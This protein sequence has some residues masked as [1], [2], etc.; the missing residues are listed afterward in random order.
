MT[1]ALVAFAAVFVTGE[2]APL[3]MEIVAARSTYENAK[4]LYQADPAQNQARYVKATVSYGTT[5]MMSPVMDR[6]LKYKEA[7]KLYR[8]ALK[9]DPENKEAAENSAMIVSIYEQMGRKVPE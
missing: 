8:D 3:K 4:G 9:I 6:T 5:M 7:L 1:T 2:D